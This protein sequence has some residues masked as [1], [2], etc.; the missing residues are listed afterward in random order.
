MLAIVCGLILNFIGQSAAQ[1]S[2]PDDAP[3]KS[4][5]VTLRAELGEAVI[6]GSYG[7]SIRPPMD[8][9]VA[10]RREF[11][12]RGTVLL[13]MI[14]PVETPDPPA[15]TVEHLVSARGVSLPDRMRQAADAIA[16]EYPDH[17][18]TRDAIAEMDGRPSGTL[19]VEYR[20]ESRPR[21]R[22]QTLVEIA[23]RNFLLF[24]L[25]VAA[26]DRPVLE[27]IYRM[28]IGSVRLLGTPLSD[29]SLKAALAAGSEWLAGIT[30]D[31][32]RSSIVPAQF[33]VFEV[34][35]RPVGLLEVYESVCRRK[36]GTSRV[37]GVEIFE[38]SWMFDSP[39]LARRMQSSAFLGDDMEI[40][41][42]QGSATSWMAADG[43]E[44]EQFEHGYE[45]ALRDH[46]VL[47][48]G[49]SRSFSEAVQQNPAFQVPK[50]YISRALMRLLP[51]LVKDMK[52]PR[53]MAFVSF[54]HERVG[55]VVQ[56]FD[57]KG[58]A[59]LPGDSTDR[60]AYRVE[61]REGIMAEPTEL[62]FD[63]DGKLLLLRSRTLSMRP[64]DLAELK[65]LF[66]RQVAAGDEAIQR[67]ERLYQQSETRFI[68]RR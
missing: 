15:I 34:A 8:W 24:R 23:P 25:D 68:R 65:R 9:V 46:D 43:D 2:G 27:P 21:F 6:D 16:L 36:V 39:R 66:E 42:W 60:K 62:Y 52:K 3:D 54:D 67:M 5:G 31:R 50:T 7:L 51:R 63:D 45:E 47:V 37:S 17:K 1:P 41:K 64:S 53:M 33:F 12:G 35:E 49:Q 30:G 10:R 28:V 48:S 38:Q 61:V 4:R 32:L 56:V 59:T 58:P 19:L 29:E 22:M 40:E 55:L 44:P 57:F 20:L 26:S 18:M 11:D 14:A 13:R